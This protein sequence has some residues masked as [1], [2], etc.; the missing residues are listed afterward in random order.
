MRRLLVFIPTLCLALSLGAQYTQTDLKVY[1]FADGLS[2]RNVFSIAQDSSGLLWFG[3]IAGLNRFD[4]YNFLDYSGDPAFAALQMISHLTLGNDSILYAAGP[5]FLVAN[6]LADGTFTP[7]KLKEGPVVRRESMVPT[8]MAAVPGGLFF[9]LQEELS[10]RLSINYFQ[11]GIDSIPKRLFDLGGQ[12]N[13]RP[14]F[15]VGDTLYCGAQQNELWLFD[16]HTGNRIGVQTINRGR[17]QP[18]RITALTE[19]E[20]ILYLLFDDGDLYTFRPESGQFSPFSSRPPVRYNQ[21]LQTLHVHP[22]GDIY[23]GGFGQLWLYDSWRDVWEDLDA[24]IRQLVK[25]TATYREVLVD[26]SGAVWLATDF[27]T[28]RL[29]RSDHLFTQYLSGGSEYC[30]NIFCS[31][32]GITE[33][34]KG[35]IYISYYNSIHVLE[36]TTN[37][38]RPL[39]PANDYFN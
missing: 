20:G 24:P 25:N 39:F 8:A 2:H 33:D 4:G 17:T 16:V 13:Q 6:N 27:G 3:T 1:N 26:L 28:I 31:T 18:G 34:A 30:S 35:N 22:N 23:V 29:T 19:A 14:L 7:Y 15:R 12:Y 36:P 9:V 32:R 37:N 21:A 10:G 5:D 11:P 38:I